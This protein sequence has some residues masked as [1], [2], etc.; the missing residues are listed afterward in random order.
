[1]EP[2]RY[3]YVQPLEFRGSNSEVKT[4]LLFLT[5]TAASGMSPRKLGGMQGGASYYVVS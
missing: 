4:A 5:V 2:L 1:M 3:T